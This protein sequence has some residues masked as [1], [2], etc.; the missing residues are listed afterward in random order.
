MDARPALQLRA[1]QRMALLPQM[2]QSIE[3][4]Q[5]AAVDLVAKV[6]EELERNEAL[7]LAAS[8]VEVGL[9]LPNDRRD[10]VAEDEWRPPRSRGGDGED[11]KSAWLAN[12]AAEAEDDLLEF[13]RRQLIWRGLE[14]EIA[15]A[16]WLLAEHLDERGL[17]SLDDDELHALVPSGDLLSVALEELQSLEPR[18]LGARSTVEAMLLQID[19][20]D[21]DRDD[22]R[23]LLEEH[24]P[25]L[26]RNKIPVVARA[27]GLE[28][29][30]VEALVGRLQRLE[31]RPAAPFREPAAE[32]MRPDAAVELGT[33]GGFEV[34][35][36][37]A[38][39]PSLCV[40]PDYESMARDRATESEVRDYVRD[41]VRSAREL[42]TA[43]AHRNKTLLRV[44]AAVMERQGPFLERGR[45][46]IQPLKMADVAEALELHASTVSR[47]I[48]GKSVQTPHGVMMLRDFF[49]GGDS[50][51][52]AGRLGIKDRLQ[53]VVAEEDPARPFSD[54][55]LVSQLRDRGI[56][57]ARRTVTKYR[58]ELAIPASWQRKR[59]G[60]R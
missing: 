45:A 33:E 40:N 46:G 58:K 43:V 52:G 48:A 1:D 42:I 41:K 4:L 25:D 27:L 15:D 54:D 2:L 5:L 37:D 50:G 16:V 44:V 9:P 22:L 10:P 51:A 3:I 49:D 53:Q 56:K 21:P 6:A 19:P 14:Q 59:F 31:T 7:E 35:V 55:E 36:D 57:V 32:A 17:L 30:D 20:H 12:I 13:V 26:A 60:N 47:A 34:R 18:G 23:A 8:G 11:G 29:A 39:L 28:P 38:S 24:L